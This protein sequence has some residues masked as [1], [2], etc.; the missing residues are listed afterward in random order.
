MTIFHLLLMLTAMATSIFLMFDLWEMERLSIIKNFGIE[1]YGSCDS[2]DFERITQK[3]G[4]FTECGCGE[5]A[6][7]GEDC[8]PITGGR[9]KHAGGKSL[10]HW[11]SMA[12]PDLDVL[13]S[14]ASCSNLVPI[15]K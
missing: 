5:F 8:P 10:L 12:M 11:M 15:E 4:G 14:E 2:L 3:W 6:F 13:F 1:R 7:N 9:T